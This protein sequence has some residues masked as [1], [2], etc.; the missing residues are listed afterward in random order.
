MEF[1]DREMAI[2]EQN[3]NE[4]IEKYSSIY[5]EVLDGS[6]Q[7]TAQEELAAKQSEL[8]NIQVRLNVCPLPPTNS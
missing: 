8:N 7:K 6:A 1:R 2:L 4:F 3:Y 5:L